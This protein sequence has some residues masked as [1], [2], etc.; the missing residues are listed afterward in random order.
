MAVT[1]DEERF[2]Q[3]VSEAL[4]Q[5]PDE[6]AVR[7]ENVA[8]LTADRPSADQARHGR[9][10]SGRTLLGLYE[11]I[12]LTRRSPSS[13]TA[14]MPDRITVFRD[15]HCRVARDEDDLRRRV[16]HTVIHEI[17]HHFGISDDRLRELDA[18]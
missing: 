15:A 10:A 8:V 16:A 18:Y 14:V 11:G 4:D 2:E 1:V 17:A 7:M 9:S 12:S 6:L 3:L 5:I 13:Y